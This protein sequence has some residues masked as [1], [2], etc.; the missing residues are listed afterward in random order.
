MSSPGTH[1]S[2]EILT[3]RIGDYTGLDQS[4]LQSATGRITYSP[5]AA[6]A[7]PGAGG[8]VARRLGKILRFNFQAGIR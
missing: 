4:I 1:P 8:A 5:A 7:S 6:G 3:F 2:I